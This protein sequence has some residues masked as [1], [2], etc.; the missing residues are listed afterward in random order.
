MITGKSANHATTSTAGSK[1]LLTMARQTVLAPERYAEGSTYRHPVRAGHPDTDGR[2]QPG[3][4]NY[5]ALP[6]RTTKAGRCLLALLVSVCW[7][8]AGCDAAATPA[9]SPMSGYGGRGPPMFKRMGGLTEAS[10]ISNLTRLHSGDLFYTFESEKCDTDTCV[11]LSSGTAELSI[12]GDRTGTGTVNGPHRIPGSTDHIKE[13]DMS[14]DAGIEC[15]CQCLPHLSTY[16]ED[17]G[18]CV[19]DIRARN[20]TSCCISHMLPMLFNGLANW[21]NF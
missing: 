8:A 6:T 10:R 1:R 16:R 17:L 21:R 18:I 5:T 19:D 3:R 12:G 20:R 7:I 15:K 2:S 11:G 14:S 4:D 9:K 13:I